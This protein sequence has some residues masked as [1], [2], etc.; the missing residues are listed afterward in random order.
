MSAI[1]CR[2]HIFFMLSEPMQHDSEPNIEDLLDR[3][4]KRLSEEGLKSTRQRDAIFETF[5]RLNKHI[6]VD[7]LLEEVREESPN[8]GYATVYR[9][10]KLLVEHGFAT[11]RQF[12][13]GQT[14][15]DPTTD[16][17]DEHDHLICVEC[18]R[19]VEFEDATVNARL[20]QIV[21]ELGTFSLSRRKVELYAQCTDP[22]CEY[23]KEKN[24]A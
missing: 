16:K 14:R 22:S 5:F 3:F 4:H 11:P 17:D 13:D 6:S 10:L 21:E 19:V 9:T 2:P 24:S 18:R 20:G 12:G 7:E 23:R 8:I 15:F 1:T